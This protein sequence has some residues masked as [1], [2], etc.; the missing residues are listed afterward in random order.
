MSAL[1]SMDS[2]SD[3]VDSLDPFPNAGHSDPEEPQLIK[4][5]D[6]PA[7]LDDYWWEQLVKARG[8]KVQLETTLRSEAAKLEAMQ[9][10]MQKLS[11]HD[12]NLKAEIQAKGVAMTQFLAD[13]HFHTLNLDVPISLKQGQ[14]EAE[15]LSDT[16]QDL[17]DAV[18]L[19]R[20]R[21]ENINV[22]IKQKGSKKVRW[23]EQQIIRARN[24]YICHI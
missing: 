8:A 24:A 11:R 16:V 3:D 22:V 7:G 6:C 5:A 9:L 4:S 14:V 1:D 19:Y 10:Y 18:L 13:K 21:V 17:S 2:D 23:A 12:D 20:S 15:S